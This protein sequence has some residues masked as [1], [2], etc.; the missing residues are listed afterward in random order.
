MCTQAQA[1][2]CGGSTKRLICCYPRNCRG[3]GLL[4]S[5]PEPQRT[6]QLLPWTPAPHLAQLP[7]RPP[8]ATHPPTPCPKSPE[9]GGSWGCQASRMEGPSLRFWQTL[10]REPILRA[11]GRRTRRHPG[12]RSP[13]GGGRAWAAVPTHRPSAEVRGGHTATGWAE[14]ETQPW[15]HAATCWVLLLSCL[16]AGPQRDAMSRNLAA[17]AGPMR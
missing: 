16:A 12:S 1:H 8:S 9:R 7:F 2:A 5:E 11:E 17:P 10:P 13:R 4:P 3:S 6:P 14:A 15:P